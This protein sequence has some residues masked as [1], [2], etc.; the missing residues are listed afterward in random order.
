L[1]DAQD[2][3]AQWKDH[4]PTN[5]LLKGFIEGFS[6]SAKPPE[7]LEIPPEA[8]EAIQ[9]SAIAGIAARAGNRLPIM[10]GRDRG[11]PKAT[12]IFDLEAM[13]KKNEEAKARIIARA[14]AKGTTS[15]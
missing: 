15:V 14:Q 11:L 7:P 1:R 8:F 6:G 3:T 9:N 5:I 12:P 13:R 2:L 10:A 4:P